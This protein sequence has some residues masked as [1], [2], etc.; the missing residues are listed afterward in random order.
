M[1][2][3]KATLQASLLADFK[4][5]SLGSDDAAAKVAEAIANG[6]DAYMKTATITVAPGILVSTAGSAVAQTGATT[7]T[8]TGT[9]S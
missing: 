4:A 8:G 9:I 2:L 7:S 3:V 1:A 5:I 6:V